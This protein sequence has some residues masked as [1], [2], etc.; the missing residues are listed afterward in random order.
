MTTNASTYFQFIQL[1][2]VAV[3]AIALRARTIRR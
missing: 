1:P 3:E 2:Q